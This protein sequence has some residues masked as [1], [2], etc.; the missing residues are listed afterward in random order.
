MD[1]PPNG[2]SLLGYLIPLHG[3][4][5]L[6]FRRLFDEEYTYGFASDRRTSLDHE[7]TR[8]FASECRGIMI[9]LR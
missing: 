8:G 4:E 1:Y 3:A 5:E 2:V 9:S 6:Y 7:Y